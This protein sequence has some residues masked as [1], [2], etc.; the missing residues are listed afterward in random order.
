MLAP[1]DRIDEGLFRSPD[2]SGIRCMQG[3]KFQCWVLPS[4]VTTS[5]S[6]PTLQ[7]SATDQ[8]PALAAKTPIQRSPSG[9]LARMYSHIP[10]RTHSQSFSADDPYTTPSKRYPHQ[11]PS[12]DR[13]QS[14]EPPER[15]ANEPNQ[16]PMTCPYRFHL[17]FPLVR[18]PLNLR[19]RGRGMDR[20]SDR[21]MV[22]RAAGA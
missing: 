20:M 18:L 7:I 16:K 3:R 4:S 22:R 19:L 8:S 13:R 2:M 9:V 17:S 10:A 12:Q 21:L 6:H 5:F 11:T 1:D 15:R 14:S